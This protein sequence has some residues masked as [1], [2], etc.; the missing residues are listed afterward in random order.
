MATAT[1]SATMFTRRYDTSSNYL[2][3]R[4]AQGA[5]A[6]NSKMVGMIN[7]SGMN[8]TN[9]VITGIT[10]ITTCTSEA[11]AGNGSTKTL[12][13]RKCLVTNPTSDSSGSGSAF[14]GTSLGTLSGTNFYDASNVS[15]P[16]DSGSSLFANLKAYFETGAHSLVIYAPDAIPSSGYSAN[17]LYL[18][19][20][21]VVLTYEEGLVYYGANGAWSKCQVF[22][23]VDGAWVQ[24]I[25]YFGNND[26]WNQ[27]GG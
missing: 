15:R 20:L 17:Y 8:M 3:S 10:F 6:G 21:K 13:F 16:V 26:T 23:P 1:F 25:P 5:Y 24:C 18:N 2:I 19:G 22:W 27:C 14:I 11:G 4:A 7:F 12:Y 9:K